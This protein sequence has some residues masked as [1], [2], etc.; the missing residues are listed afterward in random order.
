[1]TGP[2]AILSLVVLFVVGL[3]LLARVDPTRAAGEA[4]GVSFP[5]PT[6]AAD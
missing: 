2:Q 4:A 6:L 1:M 5:S 3:V